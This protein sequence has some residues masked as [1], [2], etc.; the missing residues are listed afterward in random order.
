MIPHDYHLHT[1]FSCDAKA[2][3]EEMCQAAVLQGFHEIGF[4]EH[5]DLRPEDEC[6]NWFKVED[7]YA[8]IERCRRLFESQ[9]TI[10]AGV[11]FSEPH[12][13]PQGVQSLLE[14]LPFDYVIGSLHYLGAELV[15]LPEYLRR[16]TEDQAYQD[17]FDELAR[18]T[19]TGVFDI[20]GHLDILAV[21]AKPHY[22]SYDPCRYEQAIRTVLRN[23]IERDI[24]LEIN[25]QGIRKPANILVPGVEILGWYVEMGGESFCLGSDAHIASHMGMHL[26][27]ALQTARDAGLKTLTRFEKRQK[28][29]IPLTEMNH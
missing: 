23:C 16:R 26:D 7:W 6:Y 20:L 12:C 18:M 28:Q 8:E 25:S 15:F 22:G 19:A 4:A 2:S 5:Y 13:Y 21:I 3:M 17:Y 29:P 1:T 14:K 10:R 11:E 27:I 9:L 24:L